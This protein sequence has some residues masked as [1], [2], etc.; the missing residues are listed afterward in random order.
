MKKCV[1]ELLVHF[2]SS[3]ATL[4]INNVHNKTAMISSLSGHEPD[5]LSADIP[6]QRPYLNEFNP[7]AAEE[8]VR[9]LHSRLPSH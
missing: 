5:R 6:H 4:F 8:D 2:G 1:T 9:L 7:V 3:L